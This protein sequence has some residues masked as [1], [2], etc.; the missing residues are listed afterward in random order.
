MAMW[1]FG[2]DERGGGWPGAPVAVCGAGTRPAR[3]PTPL[4]VRPNCV[5]GKP[6]GLAGGG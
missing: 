4:L 3:P 5:H 2:Q 1:L 6:K